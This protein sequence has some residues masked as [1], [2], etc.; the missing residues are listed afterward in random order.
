MP[1]KLS[2]YPYF[3]DCQVYVGLIPHQKEI[4][5]HCHPFYELVFFEYGLL[6][7]HWE[8]RQSILTRGHL[9]CIR[10]GEVHLYT[11]SKD[12]KLYN[13][14]FFLNAV[15]QKILELPAV[16]QLLM[17]KEKMHV[18]LPVAKQE[19]IKGILQEMIAE[20]AHKRSGFKETLSLLLGLLLIAMAREIECFQ[21]GENSYVPLG[22]VQRALAYLEDHSQEK[23]KLEEVALA[24]DLS[25]EQFSR[26]T[27]Q[28]VGITPSQYL[29]NIRLSQAMELLATSEMGV[30]EIAAL[31]G[32]ED[33]NYF[34]RLFKRIIGQSPSEF[35]AKGGL[36]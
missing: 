29:Q 3:S 10:P 21:G 12:A 1:R 24:H 7:H 19:K 11:R 14:L 35:R 27:R 13:C 20:L 5:P 4:Q 30:G 36:S 28:L 18:H 23:I 22:K 33:Q 6:I 17:G 16:R 2:A 15:P 26:L 31:V 32:F 25:P 34:A 9:F 8:G